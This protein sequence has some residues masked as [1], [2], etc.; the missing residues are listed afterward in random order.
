MGCFDVTYHD[1]KWPGGA[2][3]PPAVAAGGVHDLLHATGAVLPQDQVAQV[4][5][6]PQGEAGRSL[7][8]LHVLVLCSSST[9]AAASRPA[10][11]YLGNGTFQGVT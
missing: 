5:Q 1:F 10:C 7:F 4:L 11:E 8:N 2:A 6:H 9:N 3:A